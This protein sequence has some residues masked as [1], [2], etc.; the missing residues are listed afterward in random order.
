MAGQY[1][2]GCGEWNGLDMS[3]MMHHNRRFSVASGAL[4][5]F[6]CCL[7]QASEERN[8]YRRNHSITFHIPRAEEEIGDREG[9]SWKRRFWLRVWRQLGGGVCAQSGGDVTLRDSAGGRHVWCLARSAAAQ[10]A[11][12]RCPRSG[13]E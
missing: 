7:F 1:A 5:R 10:S 9:G 12:R 11:R 2:I 6:L 3:C 13:L 8:G 4:Q